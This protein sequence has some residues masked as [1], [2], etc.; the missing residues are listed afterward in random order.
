MLPA[1]SKTEFSDPC[2]K[3]LWTIIAPIPSGSFRNVY[4]GRF[5]T[6]TVL[7]YK[8]HEQKVLSCY[9]LIQEAKKKCYPPPE[10]SRS[11]TLKLI[12]KWGCNVSQQSQY[13]LKLDNEPDS[14]ANIFQSYCLPVRLI[15]GK[16][17]QKVLRINPTPSSARFCYPVRFGFVKQTIDVTNEGISYVKNCVDNLVTTEVDVGG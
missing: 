7:N 5:N 10:T 14:D 4:R 1:Y 16:D 8:K 13:R 9:S 2:N 6:R 11:G 15:C 3:V 12:C 17:N